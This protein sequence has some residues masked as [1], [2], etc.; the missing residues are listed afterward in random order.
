M[1]IILIHESVEN[2]SEDIRLKISNL[3]YELAPF[4][5][6][7]EIL[8][9][10]NHLGKVVVCFTDSRKAGKFLTTC[11]DFPDFKV[12]NI[13]CVAR[14]PIINEDVKSK[15]HQLNLRLYYPKVL[16]VLVKDLSDFFNGQIN[17][18][19]IQFNTGLE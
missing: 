11:E 14:T 12:F 5:Q 18:E 9:L 1:N 13:L 3:G 15:L 19:E 16:D 17:E 2:L 10:G 4:T 7:D 8:Q 6:S